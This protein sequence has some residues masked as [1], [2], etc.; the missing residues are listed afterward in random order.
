[1]GSLLTVTTQPFTVTTQP[2]VM[3]GPLALSQIRLEDAVHALA[4]AI[5]VWDRG[6]CRWSDSLYVRLRG[7]LHGRLEGA[8]GGVGGSRTPCAVGALDVL[9]A[10]DCCV[11]RWEPGKGDTV[12]RLHR[13]VGR[14]WRPQ[15]CDVID[16]MCRQLERWTLD[17]AQLVG[18]APVSVALRMPCPSCGT[19]FSYRRNS[20]GETLR[21]DALRVSEDG[22]SCSACDAAWTPD[23]FH[24]LARLLGCDALPTA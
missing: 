5:P 3:D 14:G 8:G 22:C 15:D 6:V 12:D 20:G 11:A 23:Q 4:D 17:A 1:M 7:A 13:L 10:V 16:G 9:V 2:E 21:T 24:W 18:D 19:R